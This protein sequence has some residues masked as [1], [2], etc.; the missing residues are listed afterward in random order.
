MGI[1]E[2][3]TF[4]ICATIVACTLVIVFAIKSNKN[5]RPDQGG[6]SAT[7]TKD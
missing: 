2:E 6:S 4:Y 7:Q 1:I 5:K 3:A